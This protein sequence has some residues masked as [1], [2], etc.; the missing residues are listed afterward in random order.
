MPF[1]LK[2]F[3]EYVVPAIR[4]K[5]PKDA[6]FKKAVMSLTKQDE[7]NGEE[8]PVPVVDEQGEPIAIDV[9]EIILV[10][11]E[12]VVEEE[13][14]AEETPADEGMTQASIERAVHKALAK[15]RPKAQRAAPIAKVDSV[16]VSVRGRR[17]KLTCFRPWDL[18]DNDAEYRAYAFGTMCQYLLSGQKNMKARD[19][20]AQRGILKVMNEGSNIAGGAFVP[21]EFSADLIRLVEEFGVIRSESRVVPMTR[22]T[23]L[24]PRRTSGLTAYAVGES[25]TITASDVGTDNVMLT[26]RKWATLTRISSELMEDSAI[27]LGDLIGT[28][29]AQVFADKEDDSGFNGDGTSTYH[30]IFGLAVKIDDGNHTAGVVDAASGNT[31]FSTLDMADFHNMTGILPRYAIANA[32][33]YIS[34]AGFSASMERLAHAQGGVTRRETEEGSQLTF[35]GYPVVISQKMNS[36][37]TAQTDTIIIL[38]GDMRQAATFG[39]RKGIEIATSTDRY[40]DQDQVAIRGIERMDFVAHDL[41]DT[42]DAG[43][44]V[45]MSTPGS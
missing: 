27:A 14:P 10:G 28:E 7:E 36:T 5:Y 19:W 3:K 2:E 4:A 37:T 16:P 30:G 43:P 29:I 42:S 31:A 6:D 24:F 41:G 45:A 13:E 35:L 26:A 15:H 21:E 32:K 12:P 40:F 22:D 8:A 44:M 11:A 9:E 20:L 33:W 23:L 39:D 34:A 17:H 38:F 1:T 25:A 18:N